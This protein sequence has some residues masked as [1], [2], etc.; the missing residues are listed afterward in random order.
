MERPKA[1]GIYYGLTVQFGKSS[2]GKLKQE[3]KE[4][5]EK[6]DKKDKKDKREKA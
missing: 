4:K 2:S 3:K 5:K 6:K 1:K